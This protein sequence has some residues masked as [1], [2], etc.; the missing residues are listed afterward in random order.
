MMDLHVG[1]IPLIRIGERRGSIRI[2][3]WNAL[4]DGW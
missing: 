4:G 1:K 3:S 2:R